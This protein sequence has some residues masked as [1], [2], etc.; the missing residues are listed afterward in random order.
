MPLMFES[1][2]SQR[3]SGSQP[4]CRRERIARLS[5][6]RLAANFPLQNSVFDFGMYA[7]R[8]ARWRCQKHPCTKMTFLLLGKA[9]SGVPGKS[10][11]WRRNR[12]PRA[13]VSR[14]TTSSGF[15]SLPRMR[16]I[17]ADRCTFVITSMS[18]H[19][20]TQYGRSPPARERM[21]S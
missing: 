18:R 20:P 15:V 4:C 13:C 8:H 14:R 7:K 6:S 5:R 12:Y 9:R 11:R 17:A 19:T 1:S 3:M 21:P 16:D 10:R 2:H